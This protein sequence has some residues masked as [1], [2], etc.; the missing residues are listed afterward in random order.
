MHLFGERTQPVVSLGNIRST[1]RTRP[2]NRDDRD[3]EAGRRACLAG[4]AAAG[5]AALEAA[6]PDVLPGGESISSRGQPRIKA[7]SGRRKHG[8]T[9]AAR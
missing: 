1:A 6:F 5:C 9:T 4:Q 2:P 3:L 8:D 7:S